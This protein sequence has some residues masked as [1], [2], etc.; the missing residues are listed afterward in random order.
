MKNWDQQRNS[1]CAT[2][3]DDGQRLAY[4]LDRNLD[5]RARFVLAAQH[6]KRIVGKGR[7]IF[8]EETQSP[9]H[10]QPVDKPDRDVRLPV[11]WALDRAELAPDGCCAG[12]VRF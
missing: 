1:R 7:F 9:M 11:E 4:A 8:A 3:S 12:G 2:L 5:A 10:L 6:D